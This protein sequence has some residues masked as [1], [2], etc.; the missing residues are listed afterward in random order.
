MGSI[1]VL[2][3]FVPLCLKRLKTEKMPTDPKKKKST[4]KPYT[5]K[6]NKGST[7]VS[8][9]AVD[10]AKAKTGAFEPRPAYSGK[11]HTNKDGKLSGITT[12]AGKYMSTPGPVQRR[13]AEKTLEYDK[14]MHQADSTKQAGVIKRF[15][16]ATRGK[17][18]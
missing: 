12:H 15:S 18:K 16:T 1:S 8:K 11:A 10:S 13:K 9:Q 4:A 14:K 17:K 5:V 7:A 3:F 6:S 2:I